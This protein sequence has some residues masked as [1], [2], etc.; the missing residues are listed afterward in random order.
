M[1]LT[2]V[3]A[4]HDVRMT[5][6][7]LEWASKNPIKRDGLKLKIGADGRIDDEDLRQFDEHLRAEW[8]NKN[9]GAEVIREIEREA[10]GRCGLCR[11]KTDAVELAHIDRL[12]IE[13]KF[14]FQHPHN[15]I[16][17]CS[18]CH[19]R[20]DVKREI[21]NS[22]IRHAKQQL[23]AYLMADVDLDV[24]RNES[25][26]GYLREASKTIDARIDTA[27]TA[28]VSRRLALIGLASDLTQ[29]VEVALTGSTAPAPVTPSAAGLRLATVSGSI[30][31][32]SPVTARLLLKYKD[33]FDA[34]EVPPNDIPI[35]DLY[36]RTPGSC[37]QCS[38]QTAIDDATCSE[39]EE[40][41]GYHEFAT[42]VG[43]GSYQ[44]HDE[45][46][47]GR[48]SKVRCECGADTFYVA[49][50]RLCDG[51]EHMWSRAAED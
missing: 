1:R 4:A 39:C 21:E 44:L 46:L 3:K 50:R 49:F 19:T 25:I 36:R 24:Q 40:N 11:D 14:H 23:L 2:L 34:G 30:S 15:L 8:P 32:Q 17:L 16:R 13:V 26:Q 7:L 29:H 38:T 28:E 27:V 37:D 41:P 6:T 51:C 31:E 33:A 47:N 22:T 5:V 45:D 43:E 18:I 42:P 12:G 10:R 35:E 9:A 20:Y 48:V